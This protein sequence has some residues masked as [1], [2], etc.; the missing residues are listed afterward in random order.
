MQEYL[1]FFVLEESDVHTRG[2]A[3]RNDALALG[4]ER[5]VFTLFAELGLGALSP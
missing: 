2:A 3:N 5:H 1:T 4:I